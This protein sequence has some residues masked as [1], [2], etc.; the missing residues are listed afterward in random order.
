MSAYNSNHHTQR[1]ERR[2]LANLSTLPCCTRKHE[3][4]LAV[5]WRDEDDEA[6]L[7]EIV[8]AYSRLMISTA[9]RFRNYS[10]PVTDL[11]QEGSIGLL[12]A[13]GRFEPL[14]EVRFS[15]Y[16]N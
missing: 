6:A 9:M 5:G 8:F 16:A 11:I 14:R 1:A 10:L 4:E 13:V 3:Y 7:H 12:Q 2:F 15:S